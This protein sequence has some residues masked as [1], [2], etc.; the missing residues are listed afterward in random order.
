MSLTRK[1][2]QSDLQRMGLLFGSLAGLGFGLALWGTNA[3][4]L[5]RNSAEPPWLMALLAILLSIGLGG[6]AGWLAA[7]RDNAF[8]AFLIWLVTG[9]VLSW[10]ALETNFH[11]IN[12][13]TELLHPEF[14][15]LHIYPLGYSNMFRWVLFMIV[16]FLS[17]LAGVF[18]L[19]LV[20]AAINAGSSL[21]RIFVVVVNL[22]MFAVVGFVTDAICQRSLR[23]PVVAVADAIRLAREDR[24]AGSLE[25]G[26]SMRALKSLGE[27]IYAPYRLYDGVHDAETL[28]TGTVHLDMDG[29]WALCSVLDGNL[30][31][32]D[33]SE[34]LFVQRLGCLFQGGSEEKCLIH[35]P[36]EAQNQLDATAQAL[37]DSPQISIASQRGDA[38]LLD[39]LGKDGVRYRCT[40]R[41]RGNTVFEGCRPNPG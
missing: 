16:G 40:L 36:A 31:F 18:Q 34:K 6:L 4:I 3:W 7:W 20:E 21:G 32:C 26:M 29:E 28:T 12:Q 39:L 33:L 22:V 35:V 38:I 5:L 19:F 41:L 2:R 13:V 37:G 15:G 30:G 27:R 10:L 14:R 23:E 17:G 25:Q 8:L 24:T 9:V 11:L 1:R